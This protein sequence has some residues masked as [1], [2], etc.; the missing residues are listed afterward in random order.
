M[1]LSCLLCPLL[2]LLLPACLPH[3]LL[4]QSKFYIREPPNDKPDWLKV[5]LTLGNTAVL[6][7]LLITQHN[8]DAAAYKRRNGLE[9]YD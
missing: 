9:I 5:G 3:A 2:Q 7:S 1:A 6:W 8:E 4:A